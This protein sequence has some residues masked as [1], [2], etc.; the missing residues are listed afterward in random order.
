MAQLEN[1]E[2]ILLLKSC[3]VKVLYHYKLYQMPFLAATMIYAVANMFNSKRALP[4]RITM[5]LGV[6]TMAVAMNHYVG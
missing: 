1:E 2:D 3:Q 6:G 5:S 4:K